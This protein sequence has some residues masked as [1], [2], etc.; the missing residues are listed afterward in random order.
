[1]REPIIEYY[2]LQKP[3]EKEFQLEIT[4]G[5]DIYGFTGTEKAVQRLALLATKNLGQALKSCLIFAEIK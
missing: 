2:G 1:M 4:V 5:K 3:Y